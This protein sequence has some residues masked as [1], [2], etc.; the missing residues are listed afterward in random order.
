MV[1]VNDGIGVIGVIG[2]TV[3]DFFELFRLSVKGATKL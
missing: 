2:V 1:G 3:I